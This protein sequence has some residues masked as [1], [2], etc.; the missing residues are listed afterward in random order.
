[1][2]EMDSTTLIHNGHSALVDDFGN[3][4]INPA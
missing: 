1:V 4:L 2:T 3:L